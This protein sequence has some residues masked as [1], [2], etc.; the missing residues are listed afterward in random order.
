MLAAIELVER[1]TLFV[2]CSVVDDHLTSPIA[3]VDPSRP[4]VDDREAESR[5]GHVA[6]VAL[7]DLE[8]AERLAAPMCRGRLELAWAPPIAAAMDDLL[9]RDPPCR[10]AVRVH[11]PSGPVRFVEATSGA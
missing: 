4:G 7:A 9:A 8:G 6:V 3:L 1:Y 2:G 11:V 10:T 5:Q